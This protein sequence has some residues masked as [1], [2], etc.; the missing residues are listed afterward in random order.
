MS[1]VD[2]PALVALAVLTAVASC[3][4]KKEPPPAPAEVDCA[5]AVENALAMSKTELKAAIPTI[6]D[7]GMAKVKDASITRCKDDHWSADSR[8]CMA[9]AKT[10]AEVGQCEARKTKEQRDN[11]VQAITTAA[12]PPPDAGSDSGSGSA[13]SGSGSG[14]GSS[15]SGSGSGSAK[16]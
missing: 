13:G 3:G 1:L 2:V 6:D 7:A 11:L 14:S 12:A 15:G 5:A 8:A 16:K 9:A 10:S 4:G